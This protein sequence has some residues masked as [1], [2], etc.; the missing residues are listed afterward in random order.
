DAQAGV[1]VDDVADLD[2]GAVGEGPMRD[3]GL[4]PLVG[5]VSLEADDRAL[6]PLVG[7]GSDEAPL[8]EDAPDR[9]DG[10]AVAVA[11]LEVGSNGGRT[12]LVSGVAELLADL[13]D[14]F[15]EG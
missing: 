13:D 4:P 2:V 7:L 15:F 11:A 9:A 6:G 3:V 12:G 14:L 5:L 1:V 8:G 10:G